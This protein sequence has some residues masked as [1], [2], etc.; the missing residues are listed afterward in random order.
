MNSRTR[1]A[2]AP[3]RTWQVSVALLKDHKG[4]F[5]YVPCRLSLA[6]DRRMPLV[7]VLFQR[8]ATAV[9]LLQT[10]AFE[11]SLCVCV[12]VFVCACVFVSVLDARFGVVLECWADKEAGSPRWR[13][14]C[15]RGCGQ[16]AFSGLPCASLRSTNLPPSSRFL[17]F[18]SQ[19]FFLQLQE[20][21]SVPEFAMT[22][23][24]EL[25][26]SRRR[27]RTSSRWVKQV[28]GGTR[29]SCRVQLAGPCVVFGPGHTVEADRFNPDSTLS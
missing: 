22:L 9:Y 21:D 18:D 25:A 3:P 11:P 4:T 12:S 10:D 20:L 6:E 17:R 7:S 26:F 16:I 29:L 14:L 15:S 5:Q 1:C 27:R 24:Q 23:G 13:G 19:R 8:F 28:W 2:F